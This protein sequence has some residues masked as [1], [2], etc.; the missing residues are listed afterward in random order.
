[1]LVPAARDL[2]TALAAFAD[3]VITDGR[4]PT[5]ASARAREDAEY[6]L[7]VMTGTGDPRAA[8]ARADVWLA[9]KGLADGGLDMAPAEIDEIELLDRAVPDDPGAVA[10]AA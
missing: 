2:R 4:C 8:V 1:M 6:T 7:C 10:P 9:D 5:T 3:A